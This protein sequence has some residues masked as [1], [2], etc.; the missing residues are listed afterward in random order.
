MSDDLERWLPIAGT[1]YAYWVSSR[2]RGRSHKRPPRMLILSQFPNDCGY[3]KVDLYIDGHQST[4]YVAHL[5]AEAFIGPRPD[6]MVVDHID[7]DLNHNH[8]TNLRYLT[9]EENS[10]RHSDDELSEWWGRQRHR[11]R[12]RDR[13]RRTVAA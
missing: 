10:S 9:H 1:D 6:G 7:F 11:P 13:K 2:G 8:Y 3:L 12:S 4:R 5:V